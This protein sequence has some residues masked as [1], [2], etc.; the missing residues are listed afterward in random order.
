[1]TLMTLTHLSIHIGHLPPQHHPLH[2]A[3]D[4]PP[5][6]GCP[7]GLAE[8]RGLGDGPLDI[9][10]NL[11]VSTRL[12]GKVEDAARVVVQLVHQVLCGG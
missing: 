5:D 7:L 9:K 8:G 12:T 10:V 6:E 1:M 11:D 2:P 4:L 3:C